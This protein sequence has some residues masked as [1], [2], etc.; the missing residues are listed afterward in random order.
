MENE[1]WTIS[2]LISG[3]LSQ[4]VQKCKTGGT[5]YLFSVTGQ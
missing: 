2:T 3:S 1:S 4:G 5:G